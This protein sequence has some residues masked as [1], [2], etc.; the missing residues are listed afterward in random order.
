MGWAYEANIVKTCWNRWAKKKNGEL[1]QSD[2]EASERLGEF[3]Q[4]VYMREEE[5]QMNKSLRTEHVKN[6]QLTEASIN[7]AGGLPD[8]S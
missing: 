5:M 4:G 7:L 8:E 2:Q 6:V 3:F 1:T